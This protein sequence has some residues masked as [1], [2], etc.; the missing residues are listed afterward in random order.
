MTPPVDA[1]HF[2][3][4]ENCKNAYLAITA[5]EFDKAKQLIKAE[6]NNDP[7]NSLVILLE[8]HLDFLHLIIGEQKQDYESFKDSK[9]ERFKAVRSSDKDSPY[10]LYTL[11]NLNLH[12]AFARLRFKDYFKALFEIKRAFHLLERNVEKHPEFL[13]NYIGLGLLHTMVGSIPKNYRWVSWLASMDGSVEQGFNELFMVLREAQK[14][15]EYEYLLNE[16]AFFLTFL[17]MNIS[18]DRGNAEKLLNTLNK[19]PNVQPLI[20]FAKL[21]I[22]KKMARNEEAIRILDEYQQSETSYPFHYLTYLRALFYLN[23]LDLTASVYFQKYIT[24]FKG[25]SY[26]KSS[27]QKMA[28]LALIQG[29][30]LRYKQLISF[31]KTEGND[32]LDGDKQAEIE[33][34]KNSIPQ[35]DLLK[36][37]LLYD[38]GYYSKSLD[39]L[40]HPELMITDFSQAELAEYYYRLARNHQ[41]LKQIEKAIRFFKTAIETGNKLPEYFAGNSALQLGLMYENRFDF[42]QAKIYYESCID[43]DFKTYKRSLDIKAKAGL[44]RLENKKGAE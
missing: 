1:Q 15:P 29:D 19:E 42:D 20:V 17:E 39:V 11:A 22:L 23:R 13:P 30:N 38:G 18:A 26:V 9:R 6:K 7:L 32:Y 27:Y 34:D 37:R 12:Y 3:F 16:T 24:E 33:S 25:G 14:N 8:N 44:S 4:S 40:Y 35:R 28:W 31:C 21:S 41:G 10:Y 36:A 43:L 5:L 2:V